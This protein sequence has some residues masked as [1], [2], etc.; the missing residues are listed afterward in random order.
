M[1]RWHPGVHLESA[2]LN[3]LGERIGQPDPMAAARARRKTAATLRQPRLGFPPAVNQS[4]HFEG[5]VLP[6][7][8]GEEVLREALVRDGPQEAF[9]RGRAHGGAPDGGSRRVR[10]AML[11]RISD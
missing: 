11:L 8:L 3:H 5:V 2:A 7:C 6:E 9:D 4:W 1:D 10:S